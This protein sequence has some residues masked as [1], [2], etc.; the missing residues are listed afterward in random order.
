MSVSFHAFIAQT[1]IR[2]SQQPEPCLRATTAGRSNISTGWCVCVCVCVFMRV[3][4][5]EDMHMFYSI[6][7]CS[8][9]V[10]VNMLLCASE[11]VCMY[12]CVHI[13]A[14]VCIPVYYKTCACPPEYAL[15]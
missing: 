15:S 1:I 4:I 8:T 11:Y 5:L 10:Y 2:S 3:H 13:Y 7:V 6:R 12:V 9:C 14:Y